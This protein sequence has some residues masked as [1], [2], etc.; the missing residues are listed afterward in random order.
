MNS[1]APNERR[2][3]HGTAAFNYYHP[4]YMIRDMILYEN[5]NFYDSKD[6]F[7][8]ENMTSC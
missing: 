4:I 6:E 1:F 5:V 3:C 2:P 8:A 7:T